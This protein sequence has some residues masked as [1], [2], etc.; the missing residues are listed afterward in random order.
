[1]EDGSMDENRLLEGAGAASA[2]A[3]VRQG[4][5]QSDVERM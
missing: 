3:K 2:R 5:G 4:K 1:M